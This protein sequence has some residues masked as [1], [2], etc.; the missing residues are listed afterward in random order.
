MKVLAVGDCGVYRYVDIRS[1]RPGG[2]SLNFAVNA[3]SLFEPKDE[4]GVLTV[5]GN[6]SGAVVVELAIAEHGLGSSIAFGADITPVQFIDR[7]ETGE[8]IFVRYDAG[9][10]ATHR[11][12]AEEQALMQRSDVVIATIFNQV[13]D[14]FESVADALANALRALDYGNPG[15]PDDPLAY[16]RRY[17]ERF[18]IG[19]VGLRPELRHLLGQVEALARDNKKIIVAT[20]GAEGSVTFSDGAPVWCS[21]VWVDNVVDTT[22]VGDTF[23]AGF[24]S[25]YAKGGDVSAAMERGAMAASRTVTEFGA[26]TAEFTSWPEIY[27]AEWDLLRHRA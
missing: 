21:A 9:A 19:F 23:A 13:V 16:M 5:L 10:M 25:V 15:P 2:I 17:T 14:Y 26:F 3:R 18:D 1:D 22:G 24:L 27:P 6:D 11:L 20:L 8:R 7:D 12:T 4:I